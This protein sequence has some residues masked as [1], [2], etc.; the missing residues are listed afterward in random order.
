[1]ILALLLQAAVAF[2]HADGVV[3][4]AQGGYRECVGFVKGHE[5]APSAIPVCLEGD[6]TYADL[7]RVTAAL[8]GRDW[9]PAKKF[10]RLSGEVRVSC[11]PKEPELALRVIYPARGET[12]DQFR[13][14]LP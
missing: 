10:A 9:F 4:G 13:V 8:T 11:G 1:M 3:K 7:E 12:A 14:E 5:K 2:V 6:G